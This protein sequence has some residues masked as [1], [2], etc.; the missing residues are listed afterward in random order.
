MD[1]LKVCYYLCIT[2]QKKAKRLYYDVIP[3]HVD[4]YLRHLKQFDIQ[5]NLEKLNN[6]IIHI[7]SDKNTKS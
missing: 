6:P 7:H 2:L 3:K 4:E 1:R 5:N